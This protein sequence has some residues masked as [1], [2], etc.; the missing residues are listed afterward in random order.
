MKKIRFLS[1]IIGVV[2]LLLGFGPYVCKYVCDL[3]MNGVND[4]A[5]VIITNLFLVVNFLALFFVK[6]KKG[7]WLKF[8]SVILSLVV[9]SFTAYTADWMA[10]IIASTS[11]KIVA[12]GLGVFAI[13]LGV[14]SYV[15]DN[16]S[17]KTEA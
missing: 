15:A 6:N 13:L 7:N 3:G 14:L 12:L 11:V 2:A 16:K 5:K 4:T 9:V 8:V 17:K 1:V 10:S